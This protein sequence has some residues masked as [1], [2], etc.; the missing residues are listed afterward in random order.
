[1]LSKKSKYAI[2][3]LVALAKKEEEGGFMRISDI[4]EQERIPRKFLEAILVDLKKQGILKSKLGANGG[5]Y[6]GKPAH[7]IM[8][9]QVFRLTD[10]P[11]ALI[12]C[13]SLNYYEPCEDCG[14]EITCGIRKM[15]IEIRDASLKILNHTS[16]ADIVA[17]ES[18]LSK[19]KKKKH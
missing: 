16:I 13:V 1:M 17:D 14:D 5:Y 3:A 10:G 8:L 6:L 7:K 19:K 4:S 18:A 12:S 9:S 2:K 15:A 11:I